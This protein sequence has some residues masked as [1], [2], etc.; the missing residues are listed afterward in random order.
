MLCAGS[1]RCTSTRACSSW[2]RENNKIVGVSQAGLTLASFDRMSDDDDVQGSQH[3]SRVWPP[4]GPAP[5]QCSLALLLH[6]CTLKFAG[7]VLLL[8]D[9]S[10]DKHRQLRPCMLEKKKTRKEREKCLTILPCM[11]PPWMAM[12]MGIDELIPLCML[13][14]DACCCCLSQVGGGGG[15]HRQL[16]NRAAQARHAR[17]AHQQ[18]LAS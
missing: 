4:P 18:R 8:L 15:P 14:T 16:P 2:E 10:A 1:V 9:W 13:R 17:Q 11:H 5:S 3:S 12:A 6:A 7:V